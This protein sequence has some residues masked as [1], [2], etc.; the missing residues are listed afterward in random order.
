MKE[1]TTLLA[2]ICLAAS[3]SL[4]GQSDFRPGY[5]IGPDQDTIYGQIKT[6]SESRNA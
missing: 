1:S 4:N 2:V 3:F 5:I 6:N